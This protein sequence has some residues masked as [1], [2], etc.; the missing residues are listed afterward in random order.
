M[1]GWRPSG[2]CVGDL[3]PR[4]RSPTV[5]QTPRGR[6]SHAVVPLPLPAACRS[7]SYR[8]LSFR[9]PAVA[10]AQRRSTTSS[11]TRR[12]PRPAATRP[13][14]CWGLHHGGLGRKDPVLSRSNRPDTGQPAR[15]H[16][17]VRTAS[18]PAP[19]PPGVQE[20]GAQGLAAEVPRRWGSALASR[21]CLASTGTGRAHPSTECTGVEGV[22][23]APVY[24]KSFQVGGA[25]TP[26]PTAAHSRLPS[27]GALTADPSRRARGELEGVPIVPSCRVVLQAHRRTACAAQPLVLVVTR[28]RKM[29]P[30][31]PFQ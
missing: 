2:A 14:P 19:G 20:E 10:R 23:T 15:V 5:S 22:S 30:H 18:P 28:S 16:R 26:P 6:S 17:P 31:G 8:F 13:P 24:V 7:S 4:K 25:G 27:F 11:S 3:S 29:F 12:V 1:I 9:S 21:R